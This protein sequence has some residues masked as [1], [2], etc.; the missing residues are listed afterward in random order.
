LIAAALAGFVAA[1]WTPARVVHL[2]DVTLI[3]IWFLLPM[4]TDS[5]VETLVLVEEIPGA[6]KLAGIRWR[7]PFLAEVWVREPKDL[8]GQK[9]TVVWRS[10]TRLPLIS[11]SS[12]VSFR[13]SVVPRLVE[14]SEVTPTV[15]P[16]LLRFNTPLDP[17]GVKDNIRPGFSATVEPVLDERTGPGSAGGSRFINY[18]RWRIIPERRLRHDSR[19]GIALSPRLSSSAGLRL[20]RAQEVTFRTPGPIRA[21]GMSPV[22][23]ERDV[24]LYPE[25]AV[26][27]DQELSGGSVRVEG[28]SGGRIRVR[29]QRLEFRPDTVLMPNRVYTVTASGMSSQG[30]PSEPVTFAFRTVDLGN[31][32]WVAVDLAGE[33][34]VSVYRGDKLIRRMIAS[35]GRPESPTPPGTYQ[36]YTRGRSFWSAKFGEGAYFYVQFMGDYLFHSVPFDESGVVKDTEHQRLGQPASHGCVRLS[37]ADAKWFYDNIPDGTIV[38]IYQ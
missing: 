11:K 14:I 17:A 5:A 9:I 4:K 10:P 33:H 6:A 35:G 13:R 24:A 25:I 29:G 36:L 23:G 15:G 3:R 31:S 18:S 2:P 30:E 27:F 21:V 26:R 28:I 32:L 22:E 34:N 38:V 1:R 8:Q 12:R 16:V 20:S 37:L 19:Y 7:N